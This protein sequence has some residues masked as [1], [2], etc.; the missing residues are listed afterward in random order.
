MTTRNTYQAQLSLGHRRVP[1]VP[2]VARGAAIAVR[3]EL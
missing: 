3:G 2:L 1:A